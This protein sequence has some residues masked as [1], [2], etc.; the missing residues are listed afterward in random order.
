MPTKGKGNSMPKGPFFIRYGR[1]GGPKI[2]I[3]K[4][5]KGRELILSRRNQTF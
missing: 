5:V 3:S 4:V 1:R 2:D